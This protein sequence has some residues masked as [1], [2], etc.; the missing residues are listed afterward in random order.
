[1]C[2]IFGIISEYE[3]PIEFA[4]RCLKRLEYRGYDSCGF[5]T[6]EG[7]LMKKVGT[8]DSLIE[9]VDKSLNSR[10][11]IT[12]TR[13][14]THGGVTEYNAHP[15]HDCSKRIFIVHNGT[16]DNYKEIKRYLEKKGH[17][18][19]SETDSELFAHFIE[20]GLR[21][22]KS[23]KEIIL[24]IF[25]S[26]KGTYAVLVLIKG[27]NKL[28]AFKKDSPL[29]IGLGDRE[30]F[31]ASDIYAFIHKTNRFI[32]LDDYEFAEI[33]PNKVIIYDRKGNVITKQEKV[34][35]WIDFTSDKEKYDHYM[36]KEIKEQPLY[37][38]IIIESLNTEQLSILE[39]F[40]DKIR[41]SN[42]IVFIAAGT[43]YH[44]SLLGAYYLRELGYNA[45]AVL[46]SEYKTLMIYDKDTLLIP[47]SQSGETMDVILAIK[48]LKNKVKDVISIVNVPYSTIQRLSSLSLEIKAGPE[49][50]VA[51][52][53]TYTNQVITM[54]GIAKKLGLNIDLSVI[55]NNIKK[56]IEE[57]EDKIKKLAKDLKNAKDIFILGRGINWFAS[58]EIALK[59]KEISYI[60][61]EALAAG[62]LKHGTLAL[63][64]E[65]TNVIALAP[66]WDERITTNIEEVE[67][68]GGIVYKISNKEEAFFVVPGDKYVFPLYSV[69]IGQLLTYYIA[70]EKNL[71]IDKPRNLAK[72]VTVI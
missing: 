14:A 60:H 23:M 67:A 13:W 7:L 38:K 66:S 54:L 16:I 53:K 62:E 52:T 36:I 68:R 10:V 45:Y 72:S 39:K 32:V 15:H 50:C 24:D 55:P 5:A 4:L 22:G 49:I 47:V 46:A 20:E 41:E 42:K 51:A 70:K 8:V 9:K 61:A 17:K 26:F 58:M 40:V 59:L 57:N 33:S 28:Y 65:G 43:S 64:E 3:I 25:K 44:A 1:M 18:F 29:V 37:S 63:I 19:Y 31:V 71:P 69:I 11:I 2:G 30:N 6:V 48:D 12:H 35:N 56:L 34:V 27:I 21:E